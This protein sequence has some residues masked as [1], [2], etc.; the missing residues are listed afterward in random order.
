MGL[1]MLFKGLSEFKN[2]LYSFKGNLFHVFFI[3]L[4][5]VKSF[6]IVGMVAILLPFFINIYPLFGGQVISENLKSFQVAMDIPVEQNFTKAVGTPNISGVSIVFQENDFREK[7]GPKK[8]S[9]FIELNDTVKFEGVSIPNPSTK[10]YANDCKTTRNECYF[11]GTKVQFWTAL[12][13][14]GVAGAI[15]G[16][17]IVGAFFYFKFYT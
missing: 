16:M 4:F 14:G 1:T 12:V 15:I 3:I 13:L 17:A 10:E 8:S 6:G 11:V 2:L 9:G 5:K 7:G